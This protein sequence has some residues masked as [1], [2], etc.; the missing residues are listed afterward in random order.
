MNIG[1]FG[2]IYKI[3]NF[4]NI[5]PIFVKLVDPVVLTLLGCTLAILANLTKLAI[6]AIFC[7]FRQ[8]SSSTGIDTPWVNIGDFGEFDKIGN[9]G[10]LLPISSY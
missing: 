7:Q 2:E 9:F 3:G 4:G 10:D 5:L 8:I 6:L 1:D